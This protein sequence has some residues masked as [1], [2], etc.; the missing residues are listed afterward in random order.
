MQRFTALFLV[1]RYQ[2]WTC[3]MLSV[4]EPPSI[5]RH[6]SGT[7]KTENPH[8]AGGRFIPSLEMPGAEGASTFGS[9]RSLSGIP[10]LP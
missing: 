1:A 10:E 2:K 7:A 9:R 4:R 6:F 3:F 5:P 8:T